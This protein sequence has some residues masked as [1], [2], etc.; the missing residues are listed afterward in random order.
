MN[1]LINLTIKSTEDEELVPFWELKII[2]EARSLTACVNDG[3]FSSKKVIKKEK[4]E[5]GVIDLI[6]QLRVSRIKS[7]IL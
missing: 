6:R 2:S 7:S 4:N 5:K 3:S 1:N